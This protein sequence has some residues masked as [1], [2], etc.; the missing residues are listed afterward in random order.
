MFCCGKFLR[1]QVFAP[2]EF[3][4]CAGLLKACRLPIVACFAWLSFAVDGLGQDQAGVSPQS[5]SPSGQTAPAARFDNTDIKATAAPGADVVDFCYHF[6]NTGDIPLVVEEFVQSCGCMKGEWDGIPVQPGATGKINAKLLTKGLR[7]K[8]RKSL[9]VKFIASGAVELTGEVEIPEALLYSE[10][11]LHWTV[12]ESPQPKQVDIII[13]SKTPLRVLS[14]SNNDPTFSCELK[15][16]EAGQRYQIVITPQET[17]TARVCV[18]QVR[19]DS[20]DPRDALQ[21]LFAI[22][23]NAKPEGAQP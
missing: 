23:E 11:T 9:H 15:T 14:V 19:T 4:H 16:I 17:K 21:G 18:M 12:S 8:V 10:R 22:V 20:K 1:H 2:G 7:G 5:G 13:Q 3:F 6:T